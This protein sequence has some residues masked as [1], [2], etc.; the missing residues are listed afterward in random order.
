[1]EKLMNLAV[2]L[3]LI[4][5]PAA[6]EVR[7]HLEGVL[8]HTLFPNATFKRSVNERGFSRAFYTL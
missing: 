2:E 1:M 7:A 8:Y 5:R 3:H 4:E 6:P